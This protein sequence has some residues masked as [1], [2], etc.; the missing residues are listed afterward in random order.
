MLTG[1][2]ELGHI[3]VK[4]VACEADDEAVEI[5]AAKNGGGFKAVLCRGAYDVKSYNVM[6]VL[7]VKGV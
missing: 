2:N 7:L 3:V 6:S 4:S 5:E 1:L